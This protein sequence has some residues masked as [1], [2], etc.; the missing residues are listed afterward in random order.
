MIPF[1]SRA[2]ARTH[3]RT[4]ACMRMIFYWDV[5]WMFYVY[6]IS[7]Q[8]IAY[9]Y[10]IFVWYLV[11]SGV[12]YKIIKIWPNQFICT[13]ARSC[14]CVCIHILWHTIDI[15]Q[16]MQIYWK[17]LVNLF[18]DM[19]KIYLKQINCLPWIYS[20]YLYE[21]SVKVYGIRQRGHY[22]YILD[23]SQM[24]LEYHAY[25]VIYFRDIL[26]TLSGYIWLSGLRL[27]GLYIIQDVWQL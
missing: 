11:L 9:E 13:C 8:Y 24:Y 22:Q 18:E 10:R 6:S 5:I 4:H 16:I 26:L 17:H 23:I 25:I 27:S 7:S 14:I 3:A 19:L 20:A 15:S 1:Q 2:H 12:L 21:L